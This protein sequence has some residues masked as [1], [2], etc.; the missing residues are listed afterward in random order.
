MAE[1]QSF[2]TLVG[3]VLLSAVFLFTGM[4]KIT[5]FGGTTEA[6]E[7][8]GLP[9]APLL[10]LAAILLELGGGLSVLAGYWC[11]VGATALILF[12]IP[13]TL[14]FHP[15]WDVVAEERLGEFAHFMKNIGLLGGLMLLV[16]WGAGEISFD[17]A[18]KPLAGRC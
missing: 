17:A 12:L 9:V 14:I 15:F 10:A 16:A 8:R 2:A 18:N 6:I 1:L 5:N 13:T 3:R 4:Q 11:R 7:S